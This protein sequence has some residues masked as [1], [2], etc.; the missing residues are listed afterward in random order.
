MLDNAGG[1]SHLKDSAE[2]VCGNLHVR[3]IIQNMTINKTDTILRKSSQ[4]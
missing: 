2:S 1:I 3:H 4:I